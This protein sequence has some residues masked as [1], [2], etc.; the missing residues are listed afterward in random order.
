MNIVW[1]IHAGKQLEDIYQF[2]KLVNEQAAVDVHNSIL[3]EVEYLQDFPRMAAIE[4]LLRD[5][6]QK[7]RSLIVKRTYKV[8]YYVKNDII[9]ISAIFDCRQDS[10]KLRNI[11]L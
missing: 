9:Y 6:P 7:Y 10:Q 1:A 8:I 3:D 2:L 4:P 11:F 5:F